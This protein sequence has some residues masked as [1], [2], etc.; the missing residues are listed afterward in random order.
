MLRKLL[1]KL[2]GDANAR[3]IKR[4]EPIVTQINKIEEGYQKLS[5][6]ELKN[7]T[8][9][10]RE[11]L[12]G[13][14]NLDE[15]LPEAFAVV[16]NACRR[17]VGQKW[18]VRGNEATWGMIPYDVQLL[19]GIVIHEGKIS[20]MKTGEG[21]T[22]VCTLPLYLNA[23]TGKGCH[24]VTVNNYLARRDAEWMGG[25]FSFL[26]LTVGVL[27]HGIPAEERRAAYAADITYGTNT[28]FGFDYLRDNM[29][30]DKKELVQRGLNYAIVDE[31]DSILID[32][33]RT[34]LIISAPAEESTS[35]YSRYSQ[36]VQQLENG[37]DYELDEKAKA[38]TLTEAGIKKMEQLLG[39]ENIYTE[40]GFSEVHHIEAALKAR[41][42]Y[43]RDKDYVVKDGEI[44]IVDE[45]TGRLMPGRRYSDG[46]HQALE[47]KEKVEVRRE[48]KTL[49]TITLQ[50]YFRLYDKLAG[51]TGT[52]I[53]E[54]EEFG[55]IYE[56]DCIAI[57]TNKPVA[58]Q[59]LA[60]SVYKNETGKFSAAVTKIKE[61]HERGQ[62]VLVGTIT[63]ERSERLSQ[64]LLRSGVPHKVLNAKHHEREAEIV[65]R[66][67]E[68]GAVTI[69]TNMAGRGTDIKLG[70]GVADLG[71]LFILGTERH[72]SRRIDNQLRGRSGRQGDPGVSQFFVSMEDSLMRL[73]GGEKMQRM[74][75][76]LKVPEDQPIENSM[77]SR[78]IES[79]QK[80]VEA[81]HFDI[82]KHL[83]EY[84]DVMNR[85]REIIYGRRRKILQHENIADEVQRILAEEAEAVV[86]AFTANR[87]RED[88]DYDEIAKHLSSVVNDSGDSIE[89]EKLREFLKVED[90]KKFSVGFLKNS[91]GEREQKLEKPEA[92][93]F[94]ER[95][96]YLSAIDRLWMEHLENMRHLREKVSLRGFGQRD[97][98]VEY[99]N[100]A[101]VSFE[102]LLGNVRGNTIRALF[103]LRVET[104]P[105]PPPTNIPE[106]AVTNEGAVEDVLTGDREG[107][108]PAEEKAISSA[109]QQ[110]LKADPKIQK[111]GSEG[112]VKV[113]AEGEVKTERA[114]NPTVVRVADEPAK[115]SDSPAK[116]KVGRNDPCPCGSGKKYKK[117]CGKD[118]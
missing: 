70:E 20:E 2:V 15:L 18:Q 102:E 34:P 74:M 111:L 48:S 32:E 105:P 68:R 23:L 84:D 91:Y 47:A 114:E 26:G 25:L 29:A 97:P 67:G 12:K 17:L 27:D 36:L 28:E 41:A 87:K 62:P 63:I 96:I 52:A 112:V 60:D 107:F 93:R 99:K 90:L 94:A 16:K 77:I 92:L 103:R 22:L 49:A 10:F 42:V 113:R 38:A 81:H 4:L 86:D 19:G 24:L 106:K 72:E 79:A 5:D 9:E 33:A 11:R 45:F 76:F 35:K 101:F 98:L 83:V 8:S 46:L 51:M 71:G 64:M 55:K 53:T 39:L 3:E 7:K 57:P 56:L 1:S 40:A 118:A 61:L 44:I 104:T 43:E 54:A 78:S 95:Q 100:E 109:A 65:S 116:A 89:A 58:R 108:T 14:A 80:K 50:N 88:W 73:F 21:K 59:D 75:E 82:R 31:V 115:N 69:A 85:Q 66:A 37:A 30:R 6:S 117:C 13:G 110:Y